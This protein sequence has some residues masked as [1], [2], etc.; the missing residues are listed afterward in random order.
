MT[1]AL[2]SPLQLMLD[3][4]DMIA[5]TTNAE[6]VCRFDENDASPSKSRLKRAKEIVRRVNLHDQLY[7]ALE[8]AELAIEEA[9]DIMHYEDDLPVTGLESWDIERIYGSMVAALGQVHEALHIAL[10]TK[11]KR[12]R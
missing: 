4:V 11:A 8:V 10:V 12:R 7:R 5:Y 2:K 3:E 1:A 6:E 9:T